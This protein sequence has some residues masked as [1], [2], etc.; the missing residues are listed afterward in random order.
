MKRLCAT[1]LLFGS[2]CCAQAA[3][4]SPTIVYIN[5]AKYY[6]H[7]VQPGETLY[8]L[9]REYGVGEQVIVEHNPEVAAGLKAD[10]RLKIPF[11]A[12]VP[13]SKSSER[14]LKKTFE[15]HRVSKGETLYAI[16]RRYEISI[17]TILEDNPNLDPTHLRLGEQILIRRKETGKGSEAQSQAEW[18]AYR[19]AL[20]SVADKGYAYHIVR[21]GETF[22]SLSRRFGITEEELSRLNNG[23]K[24]SELKAGA[25]LKIPSTETA[26]VPAADSLQVASHDSISLRELPEIT[27][28]ALR[29]TEPLEVAL[30]LPISV[31]GRANDN[32]LEFY[33]GFLLGLEQVKQRYG[34]SANLTFYNSGR[35]TTAIRRIVESPEFARTQLIVGPVYEDELHPVIQV[36]EQRSIPVV[37]PLAN[38]GGL[39]SDALFQMAA[40]PALK[41]DKVAEL[42]NGNRR[43]TL[44]YAGKTDKEFEQEVLALL[45]DRPYT[46]H[47]YRYEHPSVRKAEGSPSDLTPL[48]QNKEENVFVIL[49][50]NEV[51]VDR[52]LAAIASADTSIT[53]RGFTAPSFVVLGNARWHRFNNIDRTMFFKD[54]MVFV[55]TYHAKRDAAVITDF[56]SSYIRSFGALPTLYSYRGYDAAMIFCPAMYGDIEKDLEN[57]SYTPLQ[58]TYRFERDGEGN[59]VNR[60][61]T[62][63]NYNSDYTITI[64]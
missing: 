14:K 4:K 19:T 11:Q 21:P 28:R 59:H 48:L 3:Q 43:V 37:S 24:A 5:G 64:E 17:Q 20:N 40:D 50:E 8:S 18:E 44:I 49:A 46:R 39:R 29:R 7:T 61:W 30:M 35:D 38:I 57:T 47:N 52:I 62:R 22:Y 32:Y 54:R 9:S 56:D 2:L 12:E 55:S 10:A 31:D 60:N 15:M 51:D 41:Y 58:T 34:Y 23:L 25:M 36:A 27:F 42:F 63:V 13:R 6:V 33:Q 45:G 16:A 1:L 26:A 53:S